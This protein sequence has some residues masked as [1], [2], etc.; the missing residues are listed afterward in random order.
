MSPV[1]TTFSSGLDIQSNESI[2]EHHETTSVNI[3]ETQHLH[4]GNNIIFILNKQ[5]SQKGKKPRLHG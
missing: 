5:L 1:N 4:D 3:D 2:Q